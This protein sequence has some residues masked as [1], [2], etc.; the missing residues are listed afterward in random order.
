MDI[1][2]DELA[3]AHATGAVFS[4][5]SRHAPWGLAF[6]GQ[7]P[8]TVHI[9]L[10]GSAW[11]RPDR[12]DALPI[13]SGD[14]LLVRAGTPYTIVSE[15]GAVPVPIGEARAE[16][17]GASTSTGEGAAATVLCGAYVVAGSVGQ[18]LLDSLP[19]FAVVPSSAQSDA[20][21]SAI[22]LLAGEAAS[23]AAGE[24]AL[25][26]RLLDVNLVYALR[27][28]WNSNDQAPGW[29]RALATPHLR[30][31]LEAM[32]TDPAHRW[33]L[34]EL[35]GV[36]GVSRGAFAAAF[37]RAVGLPPARYLTALRMSRAEE[38]LIRTERTLAVIAA[39]VGY[40][41]EF[42]FATAFRRVHGRSPGRWRSEQ[43]ALIDR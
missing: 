26:D 33:T 40:A 34:P 30:L 29:Y 35:A 20:H 1:L 28:W 16:V 43:R 36:A 18:S 19:R 6:G 9:L 41:N 24:Q 17:T 15:P 23:G 22:S 25:L 27:A 31:V 4:I 37:S 11:V 42:A 12:G 7:R 5:L 32:H 21:R 2:S 38:S 14:V 10:E 13:A 3:R 39:E 8:L